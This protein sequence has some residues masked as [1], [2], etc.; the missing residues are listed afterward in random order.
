MRSQPERTR[1][2]L[3]D[4][5]LELF[6]AHGYAATTTAQIA[7][8]GVSEMTLF[9]HYP[10]KDR[11]LL[12]DPYDPVIAAAMLAQPPELPALAQVTA[13]MRTAWRALPEPEEN[14]TRRRLRIAA[15]APGLD[16]AI[17]ANTRATETAIAGTL[18]SKGTDPV[19]ARIAAAAAMG[20]LME[21]LTAWA[22]ADDDRSLGDA[23]RL[24]LDVLDE[25]V[26]R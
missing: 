17:R 10:S 3:A 1:Q 2:R 5:A 12:D 9:R 22:A 20:A 8:A 13:G 7:A 23:V 26:R 14:T 16:G 4:V 6:E 21:S 25:A 15:R 24:A 18:A 11:L 19:I